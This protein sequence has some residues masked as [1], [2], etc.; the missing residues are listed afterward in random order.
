MK[1]YCLT[2]SSK[3][4]KS[5][6]KFLSFFFKYSKTKFDIIQK[7]ITIPGNTKTFTLLKSPHVNKIAQEHFEFRIFSKQI[8]LKSFYVNKN[9]MFMKKT[10]NKLFQDVLVNLELIT[11]TKMKDKSLFLI[12]YPEN[13]KL[14]KNR[15][16]KKNIK[17]NKQKIVS[18]NC[19]SLK[20][21]FIKL[22]NFLD[23]TSVFGEV[24][25]IQ[26]V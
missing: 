20:A 3:N 8:L 26:N 21:L 19:D 15:S 5:L 14:P 4:E 10:L 2:V 12:F 24:L 13:F 16:F 9:F 6:K 1:Q 7:S 17:R 23:L 11:Y 18:K 22:S 25:V